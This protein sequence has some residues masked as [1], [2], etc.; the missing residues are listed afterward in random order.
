M[1]VRRLVGGA[2]L[3][4]VLSMKRCLFLLVLVCSLTAFG[5]IAAAQDQN[6]DFEAHSSDALGLLQPSVAAMQEALARV[7]PPGTSRAAVLETMAQLRVQTRAR[8]Q[9]RG[10]PVGDDTNIRDCRLASN[11]VLACVWFLF[12]PPS[13]RQDAMAQGIYGLTWVLR[14]RFDREDF[15]GALEVD[16]L[17]EH[18]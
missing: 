13:E 14:F 12:I 5:Q 16:L 10:D 7:F 3:S 4:H 18:L 1:N 6:F 8:E 15:L 11:D 2:A 17:I 9:A